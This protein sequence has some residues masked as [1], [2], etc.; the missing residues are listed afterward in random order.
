MIGAKSFL[1]TQILGGFTVFRAVELFGILGVIL[2]LLRSTSRS[3]FGMYMHYIV[4]VSSEVLRYVGVPEYRQRILSAFLEETRRAL[5]ESDRL[6]LVTHSLGSAMALD[7]LTE[8]PDLIRGKD[9][10]LVTM[11]SPIHRFFYRFFPGIF[12]EPVSAGRC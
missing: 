2:W 1:S 5:S 8:S 7:A 4:K 6:V 11:G 12:C 3:Q 9:V 10:T